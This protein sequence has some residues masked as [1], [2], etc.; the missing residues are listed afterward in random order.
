MSESKLDLIYSKAPTFIQNIAVTTKGLLLKNIRK[1]GLY[2]DYKKSISSRS[3]WGAEQFKDYQLKCYQELVDY[4][5]LYVP[6][7]RRVF[8]DLGITS[9][10]IS[11]L[12]DIQKIPILERSIVKKNAVDFVTEAPSTQNRISLHT[13]G[14]TGSPL[15]VQSSKTARQKN[16]AFFDSY[17]ESLGLNTDAKHIIIGGR[18]IVPSNVKTP[19]FWRYSYFQK[20]LLMSSYHLHEDYMDT[21]IDKIESF[22]PEY[23]E[24]YPSSIYT[25]C[26]HIL[27]KGRQ[28]NCKAV[29]TSAETLFPEQREVIEKA[30]NT[31]VYD[32]YGCAEMTLFVGQ[33]TQGNYHIRTDYGSL[34][35]VDDSG[36][37][38]GAGQ[39]G[40]VICTGF[41][42]K[43]M[44]MIRYSI[45]DMATLSEFK[46]CKCGLQT[47][48]LKGIQ[49]RID[50]L[51]ITSDGKSVGRMSPVLKG[52]AVHESQ[53]VQH[54]AG[55]VDLLIVP[56]KIFSPERDTPRIISA[57]Q[58]RLGS[59]CQVNVK[60]VDKIK[61]GRGGK[62][63]AVISHINSISSDL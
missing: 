17:L 36:V 31:T 22:S 12:E 14:T 4:A 1:N 8:T 3:N 19:P 13:T 15:T 11:C 48:I 52:F 10:S 53:Y 37:P 51:L 21:Y 18:I 49:G 44:P 35:I 38:V 50:D 16:Y 9:K 23:I 34:E 24:S 7:Y 32:Q 54:R 6:H 58:M 33:C 27:K 42:N 57:V 26:K 56:D 28:L 61:R 25:L 47:P 45:G 41:I 59:D 30:L 40:H 60:L 62:L 55:Y 39:S 20:S 2:S 46:S 29:I 43:T 63:K 5:R